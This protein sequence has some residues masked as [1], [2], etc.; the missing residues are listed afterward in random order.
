[1]YLDKNGGRGYFTP[2]PLTFILLLSKFYINNTL[3]NDKN[4][5]ADGFNSFFVNIG[6][7]LA[8]DIPSENRDSTELSW[9]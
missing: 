9:P 5:I 6:P 1:M 7:T 8:R 4:K 3:S 2:N